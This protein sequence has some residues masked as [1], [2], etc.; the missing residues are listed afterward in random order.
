MADCQIAKHFTLVNGTIRR[1]DDDRSDWILS[2]L[3]DY[4]APIQWLVWMLI[5]EPESS[6]CITL[7][8]RIDSACRRRRRRR[9]RHRRLVLD[10]KSLVNS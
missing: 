4:R 1:Q 8:E 9:R 6:H 5:V 3:F 2:S 10:D 7:F